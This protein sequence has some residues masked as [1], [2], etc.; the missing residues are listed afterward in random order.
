V[1]V[2]EGGGNED[3]DLFLSGCH[4]V[5]QVLTPSCPFS[6]VTPSYAR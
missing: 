1:H 4:R 3:A 5:I 6:F 2:A